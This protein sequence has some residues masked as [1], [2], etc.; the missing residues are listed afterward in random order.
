MESVR[1][2]KMVQS[3]KNCWLPG[4]SC[5]RIISHLSSDQRVDSLIDLYLGWWKLFFLL[6]KTFYQWMLNELST[7]LDTE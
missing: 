4:D 5:D 1:V 6:I 7:C 2:G 3:F